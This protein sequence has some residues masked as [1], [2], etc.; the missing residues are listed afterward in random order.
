MATARTTEAGVNVKIGAFPGGKIKPYT[1]AAG[2]SYKD[3]LRRAELL[4][5]NAEGLDVRVNGTPMSSLG[6]QMQDKDQILVFS[7]V[8]GN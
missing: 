4:T 5:G 8:R 6:G 2:T 3:G 1:F 7:K